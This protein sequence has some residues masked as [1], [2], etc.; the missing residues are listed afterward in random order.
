VIKGEAEGAFLGAGHGG[1][2]SDAEKAAHDGE[3]EKEKGDFSGADDV[4]HIGRVVGWITG[5]ISR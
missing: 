4:F 3:Q 5:G 2:L 1:G